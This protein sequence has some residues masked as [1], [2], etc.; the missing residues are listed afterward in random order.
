MKLASLKDGRDGRL[1]VVSRDLRQF[2]PAEPVVR[3]LQQALDDWARVAPLLAEIAAGLEHGT[4]A[5]ER[6]RERTAASP[7]PRAYQWVDGSAYLN[8]VELV[9]R[10]RGAGIGKW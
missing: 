1:V 8:H 10:A 5:A 2:A 7:L 4:T 3:T 6:F 9:R